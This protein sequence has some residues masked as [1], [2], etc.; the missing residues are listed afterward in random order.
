VE[1]DQIRELVVRLRQVELLKQSGIPLESACKD[2]SVT[3]EEFRWWKSGRFREDISKD[4]YISLLEEENAKLRSY[5]EMSSS[6]L[7]ELYYRLMARDM[8]F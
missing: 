4:D 7:S 3:L 2:M 6:E 8:V 5:L 1:R